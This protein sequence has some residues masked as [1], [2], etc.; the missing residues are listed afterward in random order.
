MAI[1]FQKIKNHVNEIL[2]E[3]LMENIRLSH[4]FLRDVSTNLHIH[5]MRNA[6]FTL[7][8]RFLRVS[9]LEKHYTQN[10]TRIEQIFNA[11]CFLSSGKKKI[12]T[13]AIK[14]FV[15]S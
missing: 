13:I 1:N 10:K 15:S 8:Y 4:S 6:F 3:I 11:I 5:T 9:F 2:Y 14:G 12:K 7:F